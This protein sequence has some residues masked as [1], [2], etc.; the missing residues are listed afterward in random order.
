MVTLMNLF[1]MGGVGLAQ[2]LTGQVVEGFGVSSGDGHGWVAMAPHGG[3]IESGTDEQAHYMYEE[4]GKDSKYAA[5]RRPSL[6][7]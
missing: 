7:T 5:T 6:V 1:V 3:D 4:W 2:A